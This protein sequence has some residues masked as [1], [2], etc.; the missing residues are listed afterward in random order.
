MHPSLC[1]IP[2]NK[3]EFY[4]FNTHSL[5]QA[6]H[7]LINWCFKNAELLRN[8]TV[9]E[10]GSGVGLCGIAVS[11]LCNPSRF[12]FSDCHPA[13]INALIENVKINSA[14]EFSSENMDSHL[15]EVADRVMWSGKLGASNIA[16]THLPWEEVANQHLAVGFAPKFVIASGRFGI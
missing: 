10:L 11:L 14:V 2:T 1:F 16:I 12:I 7:V 5:F 3:L 8:S 15:T 13:V 6:A 9:L 4:F